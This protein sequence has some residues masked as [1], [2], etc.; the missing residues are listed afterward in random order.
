[1][2]TPLDLKKLNPPQREAVL[3]GNGPLLVLAGAG[4]GKPS[5]LSYRIAHLISARHQPGSAILGLSFTRKAAG[6]LK[7]RVRKLVTN[8]AGPR[9]GHGLTLTTF[10]SLCVRFLRQHSQLLGFS[11]NFTILDQH[12]Q[13]DVIRTLLKNLHV[14]DRRFDPQTILFE[15]GQ[16]K[17]RFLVGDR[18][19][20]YFEENKKLPPDYSDVIATVYPKYAAQLRALN[21]MDFD[22]LLYLAVKL[23]EEHADVREG[24]GLKFRHILVDEYQDTNP[25]QFRLLRLLTE[26]HQNLCVVGDDDQSI[27][28]WRG[29]DARHILEFTSHFPAARTITLDQNYR[30]TSRILNAANEVISR[31]TQRHPKKLWSDRGEGEP[32]HHVIV[33]E[34]RSEAEF[35]AEEILKRAQTSVEGKPVQ[36]RPWKDF[37]IL[38]RS[39][40]QSRLFEE[41]LRLRKIPYKLVGALSFLDRKEV[42]DLFSYLKIIANPKDDGAV[43]RILNWPPRS[44]G[45]AAI[46]GIS[47]RAT[48]DGTSFFEALTHANEAAPRAAG[49]IHSFVAMI[50]Q[51]RT[52]LHQLPA[53]P[54]ALAGWGR[55]IL[56]KIGASAALQAESDDAA[57]AVKKLEN[58]EELINAMGQ[59]SA[60]DLR[61]ELGEGKELTAPLLLREFLSRML[62]QAQ[63]EIDDK[64]DQA[65]DQER[66]QVTLLTLHGAKGLEYPIVFMVGLEEGLL[67]HRRTIEE[68][69][70]FSEER[71]LC[72]VG[73]TR[74]KDHL[75][76]TRARTRIRYGKAVP[77]HPSRFL[78]E[79][80]QDQIVHQNL[81]LGPDHPTN[82]P[83]AQAA[84]EQQHEERVKGFLSQIRSQILTNPPRK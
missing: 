20:S 32:I 60:D 21:A 10:H 24:Y 45:R 18:A 51:Q 63:D 53:D 33:E 77:R 52:D 48:A 9:A 55:R 42:K 25:A 36:T 59:L 65:K 43:R 22:D 29:A 38:Y 5:P 71:R 3:H 35:V 39:N 79:L 82:S 75:I 4:S 17:N 47:S 15:I 68:G 66:D 14:D 64:K 11:D 49:A 76:L 81:S 50:N 41:A 12:D 6:E 8:V 61:E 13:L 58:M 83:V 69:T 74:A 80:P 84:A 70:D 67:P 31:N 28:A 34:D 23:L 30:S 16:A 37:A 27:Y 73:I 78:D 7:E 46:E 44:I 2:A 72:Y 54:A 62:L 57:Q 26:R 56:E 1:M 40:P 19:L